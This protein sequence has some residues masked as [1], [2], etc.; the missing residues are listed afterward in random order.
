M[1]K[2]TSAASAALL[3]AGCASFSPDGG[4]GKVSELT[5][6]RTG[7]S[8]TLQRS[9]SDVDTASGASPSCSSSPDGGQR[10]RDCAVEL[11]DLGRQA[12]RSWASPKLTGCV[13]AG[14]PTRPFPSADSAG[15]A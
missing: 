6:E 9:E 1:M 15:T 11:Q 14:W 10:R 5:K 8:V 3:L 12:F 7:Q 13:L 4:A 2:L